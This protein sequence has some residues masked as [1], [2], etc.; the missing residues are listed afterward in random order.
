M[1]QASLDSLLEESSVD[2]TVDVIICLMRR[3]MIRLVTIQLPLCVL[4]AN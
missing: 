2:M 4:S 1:Q 3:K